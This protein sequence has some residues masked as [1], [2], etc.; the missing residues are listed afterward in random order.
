M[1]PSITH[2]LMRLSMAKWLHPKSTT[3]LIVVDAGGDGFESEQMYEA[4]ILFG[5][6]YCRTAG[7]VRG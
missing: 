1:I 6:S 2:P 3:V 7:I 5:I 4:K